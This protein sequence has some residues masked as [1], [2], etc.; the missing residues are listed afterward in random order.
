MP[1]ILRSTYVC[2][3]CAVMPV[4]LKLTLTVCSLVC[5]QPGQHTPEYLMAEAAENNFC[6]Q[7]MLC[8]GRLSVPIAPLVDYDVHEVFLSVFLL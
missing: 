1:S 6:R 8:P 4:T 2:A 7:S 5:L 3:E